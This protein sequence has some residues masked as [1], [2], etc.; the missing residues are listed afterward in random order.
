MTEDSEDHLHVHPDAYEII[1]DLK[2]AGKPLGL[3][4][5]RHLDSMK[6]APWYNPDQ[7]FGEFIALVHCELSE[8]M[9]EWRKG[10]PPDEVYYEELHE[11]HAPLAMKDKPEGVPIEFAD[12]I[13]RILMKCAELGIDIDEAIRLKMAYNKNRAWKD[14]QHLRVNEVNVGDRVG[15]F[16]DN[17]SQFT[18]TFGW[19]DALLGP[20]ICGCPEFMAIG[21]EDGH[22]HYRCQNC[23][24]VF[25]QLEARLVP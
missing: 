17:G 1:R 7:N 5:A 15:L 8:A 21:E 14:G 3:L 9:D 23:G 11:P 13:L 20:G 10:S 2:F 19:R 25:T 22:M 16:H 6:G 4:A 12:A 24:A 18:C